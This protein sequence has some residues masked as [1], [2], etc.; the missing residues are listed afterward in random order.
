MITLS[1]YT[2]MS[3]KI[4]KYLSQIKCKLM[5]QEIEINWKQAKGEIW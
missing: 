3:Q 5:K 1:Y 2:Q 4:K